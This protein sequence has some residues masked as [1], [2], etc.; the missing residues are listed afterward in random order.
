MP[1]LEHDEV[2]EHPG[3]VGFRLP[4]TAHQVL[5]DGSVKDALIAD[6]LFG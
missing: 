4:V 2:P 3:G 5:N 6:P 1:F